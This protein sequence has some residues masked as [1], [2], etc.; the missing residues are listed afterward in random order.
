MSHNFSYETIFSHIKSF[1]NSLY[2]LFSEYPLWIGQSIVGIL[3]GS[4]LAFITKRWGKQIAYI[5]F[6]V[7]TGITILWHLKIIVIKPHAITH[8]LGIKSLHYNDIVNDVKFFCDTH[9]IE[10][11][12]GLAAYVFFLRSK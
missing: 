8:L 10:I 7:I 4:L 6:I 2:Y 11:I 3:C 9:I 5:T 12:A 1:F